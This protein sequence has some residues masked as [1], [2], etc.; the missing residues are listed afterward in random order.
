MGVEAVLEPMLA[1]TQRLFPT[2]RVIQTYLEPDVGDPDW[3][4]MVYEVRVP[5]EDVPDRPGITRSWNDELFRLV[6]RPTKA[7][8]V[9]CLSRETT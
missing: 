4:F 7:T 8:F 2:A 6:P 1:V 3:K 9:L 5:I